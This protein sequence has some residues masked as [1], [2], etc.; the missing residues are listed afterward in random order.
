[1]TLGIDAG[2]R[3]LK[4]MK[5]Y[6]IDYVNVG[7]QSVTRDLMVEDYTLRM[8]PHFVTGRDTAYHAA[9][10]RQ[11]QQ[12]PG[13]MLTV[14]EIATSG[15]R[16]MMRFSEHGRR[17]ADGALCAWG[18]I[19]LYRWNGEKLVHNNVE[20]D[21]WARRRQIAERVPDQ[22]DHPAL[23]PFTGKA[24][25]PDLSAEAAVKSW[26]SSGTLAT[27]ANVYCDDAWQGGPQMHAIEQESITINDLFSVGNAVAFHI[28]QHGTTAPDFGSVPQGTP[29]QLHAAGIVHVVDDRVASGRVI[30]NR[31]EMERAARSA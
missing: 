8:G 9:T 29:A 16:L 30:R 14:H 23:A 3:F 13:L 15:D 28:T 7:D 18:G 6:C 2:T 31:L 11:M 21:Y 24:Q 4:L 17:A 22:V 5:R 26:L 27:T 25:A 19:G 10:A 1:M 20:Q 12:Y